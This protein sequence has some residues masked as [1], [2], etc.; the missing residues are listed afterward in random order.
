MWFICHSILCNKT[1]FVTDD[2]CN[3]YTL[4]HVA[5]MKVGYWLMSN[6]HFICDCNSVF[7]FSFSV[8]NNFLFCFV[9]IFKTIEYMFNYY[10]FF[11]L[12]FILLPVA[13]IWTSCTICKI[14]EC[15]WKLAS[16]FHIL[17]KAIT[18][19]FLN[20]IC[21][22]LRRYSVFMNLN[23]ST[24]SSFCLIIKGT[25]KGGEGGGGYERRGGGR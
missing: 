25:K 21:S 10:T 12:D 18:S 13:G 3:M 9:I 1:T 16:L 8:P 6:K 15:S 14:D 7:A 23:K 11:W 19:L 20:N 22:W 24:I 5:H 17:N 2:T 4:L